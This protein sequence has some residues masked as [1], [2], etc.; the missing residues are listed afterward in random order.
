LQLE[1]DA[2]AAG[3]MAL[4]ISALYLAAV[5]PIAVLLSAASLY[6]GL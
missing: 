2:K 6:A 4:T 3:S 1:D 5:G